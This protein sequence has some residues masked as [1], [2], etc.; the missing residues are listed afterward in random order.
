[1][2]HDLGGSDLKRQ[3]DSRNQYQQGINGGG[4]PKPAG[5]EKSG[6]RNV[7]DEVGRRSQTGAGQQDEASRK[8][9]GSQRFR[10]LCRS[11]QINET[12]ITKQ[13]K[14]CERSVHNAGGG[15]EFEA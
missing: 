4:V 9:T 3:R 15:W 7:V 6:N 8:N 11:V 13:A 14:P 1:L 12:P 10:F 5:A 2:R